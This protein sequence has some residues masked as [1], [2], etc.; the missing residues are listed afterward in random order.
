MT[1][2]R[3]LALE[4]K[5]NDEPWTAAVVEFRQRYAC[6]EIT[7]AGTTLRIPW[8]EVA[9]WIQWLGAVSEERDIDG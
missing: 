7:H 9:S 8:S 2:T 5:K 4:T 1:D 6:V 3:Y